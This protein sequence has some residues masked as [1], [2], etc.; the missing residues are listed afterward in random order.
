MQKQIQKA[1][2]QCKAL[3]TTTLPQFLKPALAMSKTELL[4]IRGH[5][6][7]ILV[8]QFMAFAKTGNTLTEELML[9]TEARDKASRAIR[10]NVPPNEA[11]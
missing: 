9:Q 8:A 10:R 3:N 2:A 1:L 11:V 6:N 4:N 7:S 5:A